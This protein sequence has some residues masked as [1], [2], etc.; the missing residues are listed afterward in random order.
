MIHQIKILSSFAKAILDGDKTFEIRENDRGYQKGDILQFK[1]IDKYG[2]R[3]LNIDLFEA[4]ITYVLSGWGLKDGYV[5]LG[6]KVI[7][8][9][10]EVGIE[11]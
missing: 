9:T 4:E 5:A 6:I 1:P 8:D 2:V 3:D 10:H 7:R 11:K